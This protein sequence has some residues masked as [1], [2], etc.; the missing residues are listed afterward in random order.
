MKIKWI[1]TSLAACFF[2]ASQMLMGQ[3]PPQVQGFSPQG[4]VKRIRQVRVRFSDAI[5]PLG[6]PR[7]IVQPFDINCPEK[8]MARWADGRNW[9]FDFDRDL[10]AGVRCEFK[11]KDGLKTLAGQEIA[12]KKVFSFSTGGPSILTSNPYQG[13]DYV[14]EDQIFILELDGEPTEESVLSDVYFT[15]E[16]LIERVGI[17]IVTGEERDRILKTAYRYSRHKAQAHPLLLI[18]AKQRFPNKA[19]ISLVWGKS[20]AS[21]TGVTNIK[22][23]ILPFFTRQPFIATFQCGRVNPQADCVPVSL[24]QLVFTSE[25]NWNDVEKAVLRGPNGQAWRPQSTEMSDEE[26]T[27]KG[28]KFIQRI[29]FKGPFPEKAEFKVEIPAGILDDSGRKL[30]NAD[31]FPLTVRTDEYPPLAKFAADFGILELNAD[32]ALPVTLRNVE[33]EISGQMLTV[34]EEPSTIERADIT[35]KDAGLSE[36]MR[37]MIYKVPSDKPAQILLWLNKI[38]DRNY[39]DREKSYLTPAA[40][41]QAK[42]FSLPKPNG[43]KA[44]EVVGIPLPKPGFYVVE[45]KSNILGA[46][47]LGQAKPMYVP[48]T[49]LVTNLLAHF[50]W[51]IESSL[52]WVTTLDKAQPAGGASVQIYNCK[53]EVVWQGQTDPNGIA[54]IDKLPRR[55]GVPQCSYRPLDSGLLVTARLG[56]DLTFVH[57]S[58]NEG[59]ESWRFQLPTEY[60]FSLI[61]AQTVFDRSLFRAGETVHMKHILRRHVISGFALYP[62]AARPRKV[63]IEHAGSGQNYELP[64]QWDANGIAESTWNIP[65]EAKLGEYQVT[66][67]L[68]QRS[69][70]YQR[71]SGFFRVEEYRVP[72]MRGTVRAPAGPLVS[73]PDI[74]VDL[75]VSYLAGG[76]AGNLPVKFRHR[77]QPRM[78]SPG[79]GFEDF[80]FSNGALKEGLFRSGDDVEQEEQ[81]SF[82]LKSTE[83]TLDNLGSVRTTISGLPKTVKPVEV[84]TE[85]EFRDPNGEVQTVSSTIPLWPAHRLIGIKPDSWALSGE[86]LKFQVAV[87]D[88]S[89]KPLADTPVKVDLFQSSRFSHRKRL[90]GGFYAYESYSEVKKLKTICEG[91][92]DSRGLLL[93]AASSPVSGNVILQASTQEASGEEAVANRDVWVAGKNQWWFSAHDDDRID[94]LPEKKRYEPGEKARFQVRM[95]FKEATALITMEREGVGEAIIQH[96]SG[97]SPVIEI[98]V[99]G[100]FAPNIFVS[101]LVVRGRVSDVEPTATVDLGR[102]AYKLGIAEINVGWR[103]HELKVKVSSDREVYKVR[104]KAKVSIV[105]KT[106]DGKIPPRGSEV[107]VAA[108]DEGLLELMPNRSWQLLEAMMGKRGYG[109]ETA[110]AQTYLVGKRHFGLK[111]LPTGGGGGRQLTRELFDT[112]LL[113]KG[114]VQLDANG[115]ASV[116]IPLNDSLTSFRIVAVATS[117]IDRF[118]TGF[119]SIRSTQD[120]IILP[121]IAPVVRQG[122]KFRSEFTLRN[123]TEHSINVQVTA[124][125]KDLGD[126]LKPVSL[127]MASGESKVIGWNITAPLNVDSLRYE[128]E[129]KSSDGGSDRLAVAQRVVPAVPVRAFQATLL[130]VE[131]ETRMEVERPADALPGPGGV[132]I[133]LRSTLLDGMA[134]VSDYMRNYPYFCLEQEVSRA[135][136]LRDQ[137]RWNTLMERL[138]SYLDGDGLAKYFPSMQLGSDV[139]TSY[140]I[141]IADEA[142]WKIPPNSLERMVG[143]L[144]DFIEGRVIRYSSL[145]TADLSIRKLAAVEALSRGGQA[146]PNL[147][148]S[149]TIEPN[150]WPTSAVIDWFNILRRLP[151]IRNQAERLKEAEQI[152]RTRLNFQGT[153]M[154]FS[155]ERTDFWWWCMVS[156]DQNSVR[157]LLSMLQSPEWKEDIPRLVRGA[158][159]RQKRGHWDT[160]VANAWGVIAMEKFSRAFEK[161]P[162]TGTTKASL[163]GET[164]SVD[165]ST[166]PKGKTV[167]FG[168]PKQRSAVS[169]SP[170]TTGAPWATIQ[171]LAAIPLRE[172]FSTGYKITKT[173][174]PVEQK[175]RGVWSTG[176]IARVRLQLE[177]QSDMTW[178]V[179][180]DP[181]PGGAAILGTGLGRDSMMATQGEVRKG[182]VWPAFEERSFESFRAYYEFVPK[183]QWTVEYT[184]RLNNE[185]QFNLPPTRAEAM[186]SPEMFGEIPNGVF[187]VNDGRR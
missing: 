166:D 42:S 83:L 8:G 113:W 91:K 39:E 112:L 174:T 33:P 87:T 120:L 23:Q 55:E 131:K 98:P 41:A 173:I 110:T 157:L 36:K 64:V 65:K 12:G 186:Y 187:K 80:V 59:I 16:G 137:T 168:W 158:L 164:Q 90:V 149:I 150:L 63:V 129:A 185:G 56:D 62:E 44:F 146:Q 159:G 101:V 52:V 24:M 177:A 161:T 66:L 124:N 153:T 142:G 11:L 169:I 181:I 126:A 125:V 28:D 75:T 26:R 49:V 99:K 105:V 60:D 148:S 140:L 102:P 152:L 20:V 172:P 53:G 114:R 123:T 5:V 67:P 121:G 94:L 154:G 74:T 48:T 3:Q 18:Q 88:L 141:A 182:W 77:L 147:I 79:S 167:S 162:V 82:E 68:S 70:G 151:A 134:G 1:A 119:T 139:L 135:V 93:C 133:L 40:A 156:P 32:P 170:A 34:N 89:F 165:W 47:L 136:A 103:A 143:G 71:P 84:L 106:P 17:R 58:W 100:N 108:V 9:V 115:E 171:I 86:S 4:T 111:A 76:G 15:V 95:P 25:V 109:V 128:V 10:S 13:T 6:D 104:E 184:V 155:T 92:T 38:H 73:P 118:G 30:S 72:L 69:T 116:E 183:G 107:A 22:D 57:T 19:K 160:T 180:S 130:Q 43:G 163:A 46:A 144:R 145:P 35:R 78:V 31:S 179:V 175:T 14:N 2:I 178:V 85:L 132:H 127:T 37:G 97:N 81:R 61:A 176:D 122:D 54:R 117:G 29:T 51:G 7:D 138:P 96:L 27:G 45:I 50:K 21:T